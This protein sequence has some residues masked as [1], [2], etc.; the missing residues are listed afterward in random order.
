MDLVHGLAA[1]MNRALKGETS[2]QTQYVAYCT[3]NVMGQH[4]IVRGIGQHFEVRQF[5]HRDYNNNKARE[6]LIQEML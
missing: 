1:Q 3:Y 4:A 6:Y 2:R 5:L